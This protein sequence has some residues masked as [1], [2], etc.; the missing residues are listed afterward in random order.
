MR[1]MQVPHAVRIRLKRLA[2]GGVGGGRDGER[3]VA[4]LGVTGGM[5]IADI[6]SGFGD[7]AVRFAEAVGPTG[8][9]YAVDTDAD[10]RD[11][12]ARSAERRGL[13]HLKT[14]AASDDDPRLPEPVDLAFLSS[15]FHHL[16]APV[17][18]FERVRGLLRPGGRVAIL[19]GRPSL[20]SGWFGHATEPVDVVAALAAAGF[21]RR[22]GADIV[23]FSSLQTFVPAR[24]EDEP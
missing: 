17:P 22:D 8:V 12:V 15:S 5:R 11:E 20:L 14:I 21:R 1:R 23:R 19:E 13:K 16:D 7:F 3:V 10:L 4:W 6:G 9:V 2:Q 24:G 18:Y